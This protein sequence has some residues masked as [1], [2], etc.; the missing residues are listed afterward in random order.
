M[1]SEKYVV[2]KLEEFERM[3]GALTLEVDASIPEDIARRKLNDAV[4]LRLQDRF[5][6]HGLRAY[7]GTLITAA[8]IMAENPSIGTQQSI[9]ELLEIADYFHGKADEARSLRERGEAGTPD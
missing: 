2:F 6:E 7:A 4:V 8:D 3:M 1:P 9:F 5:S